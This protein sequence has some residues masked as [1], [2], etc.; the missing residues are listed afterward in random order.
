MMQMT[1]G[2][3]HDGSWETSREVAVVTPVSVSDSHPRLDGWKG[4]A[5]SLRRGTTHEMDY[6]SV[7][8]PAVGGPAGC[9]KHRRPAPETGAMSDTARAIRSTA[10]STSRRGSR[11]GPRSALAQAADEGALQR[12]AQARDAL[13]SLVTEAHPGGHRGG[14]VDI[15]RLTGRGKQRLRVRSR[16]GAAAAGGPDRHLPRVLVHRS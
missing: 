7:G 3:L 16:L 6:T 15:L 5:Q 2:V 12:V 11:H 4:I 9:S 14:L 1:Y 8:L 13:D 10:A